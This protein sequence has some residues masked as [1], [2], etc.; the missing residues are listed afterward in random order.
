MSLTVSEI[1][2]PDEYVAWDTFVAQH[3]EG[4][5]AQLS[6]WASL[7]QQFEWQPHILVVRAGDK[8]VAGALMMDRVLLGKKLSYV[9]YGPLVDAAVDEAWP[10]LLDGLTRESR[11][12][13]A[14]RLEPHE[15]LQEGKRARLQEVLEQSGFRHVDKFLQPEATLLLDLNQSEDELLAGMRQTTR[16]YIRQAERAGLEVVIDTTG[17]RLSDFYTALQEVNQRRQFGVHTLEYYTKAWEALEGGKLVQ[18]YLLMVQKGG[19]VLGSYFVVRVGD[20]SWELYGG[21]NEEGM[22]LKANYLLKWQSILRMKRDGVT[23]YDQWG[24][25]PISSGQEQGAREKGEVMYDKQHHLAGV[26]YFKEGFGGRRVAYIG[27]YDKVNQPLTY[28]LA[29]AARKL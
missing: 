5:F 26:T 12:S 27:S 16:R 14:L 28:T 7:K 29:R 8:V 1:S 2:S 21:V 22:Q 20:K 13:V 3:V 10:L 9:P 19:K 17:D 24:V 11:N 15:K 6:G 18:P 25:A 4:S 23:V